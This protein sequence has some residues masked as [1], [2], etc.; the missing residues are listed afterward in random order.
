MKNNVTVNLSC[1][2]QKGLCVSR[3]KLGLCTFNLSN[4]NFEKDTGILKM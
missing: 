4:L 2:F 1:H 3:I